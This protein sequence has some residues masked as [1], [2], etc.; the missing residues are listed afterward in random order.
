VYLYRRGRRAARRALVPRPHL[1]RIGPYE[2]LRLTDATTAKAPMIVSPRSEAARVR[3]PRCRGEG[4]EKPPRV[5]RELRLGRQ[6][7]PA[8]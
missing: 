8:G 6:Q 2:R 3:L 1:P 4:P 5:S 7:L